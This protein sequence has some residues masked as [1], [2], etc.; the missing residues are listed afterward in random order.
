MLAGAQGRQTNSAEQHFRKGVGYS[1]L[2]PRRSNC[3][4]IRREFTYM[5][6]LQK[7]ASNINRLPGCGVHQPDGGLAASN[8][9]DLARDVF[10]E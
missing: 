2:A 3:S 1:R 9:I 8:V 7:L 4:R 5:V 10:S 6:R